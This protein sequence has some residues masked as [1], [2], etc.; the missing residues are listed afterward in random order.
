MAISRESSTKRWPR[1]DMEIFSVFRQILGWIL[2]TTNWLGRERFGRTDKHIP[3]IINNLK[4]DTPSGLSP[5][6]RAWFIILLPVRV[7]R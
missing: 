4:N 3:K 2:V 7:P 1:I 5:S 6:A